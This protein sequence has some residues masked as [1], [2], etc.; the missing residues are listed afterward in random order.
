MKYHI[1]NL[2]K[3]LPYNFFPFRYFYL[4]FTTFYSPKFAH[5]TKLL[6]MPRLEAL[7]YMSEMPG[8]VNAIEKAYS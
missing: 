5:L 2:K 6:P 4:H 8:P 3:I 7:Q 1:F